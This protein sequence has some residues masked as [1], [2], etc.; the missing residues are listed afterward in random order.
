[1]IITGTKTGSAPVPEDVEMIRS[2]V[3]VP[4]LIGSGLSAGNAEQLVPVIDGAI[5]GSSFKVDGRIENNTDPRRVQ[6]FM[7]KV[8]Q[9][10]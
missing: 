6:A 3:S 7:E 4:I 5:V 1:V 8:R 2:A 9:L 10:R